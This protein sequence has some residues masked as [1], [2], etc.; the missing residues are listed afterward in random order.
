MAKLKYT[1]RFFLVRLQFLGFRYH[2]WQKQKTGHKTIQEMLDKTLWFI[3]GEYNSKTLGASRTD[4]MVSAD[5]FICKITTKVETTAETLLTELN[6]NLPQDIRVLDIIQTQKDRNIIDESKT[7]TYHYYFCNEEKANPMISPYMTNFIDDLDFELVKEAAKVF[8]GHHD[9]KRFCYRPTPKKI[10]K[11][12]VL[13]SLVKENDE[14]T[15]SFFPKKSYIF[16]VKAQ[17]FMRHQ[18]R[19]MMGAL[20]LVGSKKM[21]LDD[22]KECLLGESFERVPLIAPASGLKLFK[23]DFN[24]SD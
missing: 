4:A 11:R 20:I 21:T 15:A 6:K 13:S 16:E 22:L 23:T 5:D 9:F 3:L 19:I 12:E 24:F 8:E 1:P 17:G 14:L 2:G 7:K 10:F 18:V